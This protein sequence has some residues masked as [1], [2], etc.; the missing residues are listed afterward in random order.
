MDILPASVD[1]LWRAV[2]MIHAGEVVAHATE[3]CYGLACDLTNADAVARLF[4]IKDRPGDQPVSALVP[5]IDAAKEWVEWGDV[6][7]ELARKHLPGPLTIVLRAVE[8]LYVVPDLDRIKTQN[9]GIRIS[10]NPVALELAKRCRV[11]LSTTSANLHGQPNPYS[12]EEIV[13]QYHDRDLR[14][15]LALDSGVLPRNE[16]S[17]VVVVE[18]ESFS[19]VRSGSLF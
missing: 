6:A 5:S 17:A 9:I 13:A 4:A 2:R 16:P 19:I 3:T 11:P 1:A 8:Q 12:V 18:G 15:D 10:S 7:E 14:P